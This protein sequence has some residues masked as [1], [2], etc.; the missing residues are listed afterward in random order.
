MRKRFV[1]ALVFCVI[2]SLCNS[3]KLIFENLNVNN[4]LPA[5]EVY[6]VIQDHKGYVWVFTEYGIVKHNGTNFV[7]VCKNISLKES[8]V[9]G[10]CEAPSGDIFFINS[11]SKVY[12]VRN[13]R[14]YRVKGIESATKFIVRTGGIFANNLHVDGKGTIRFST[15]DDWFEFNTSQYSIEGIPK[16]KKCIP[17]VETEYPVKNGKIT[18]PIVVNISKLFPDQ[19]YYVENRLVKEPDQRKQNTF[20]GRTILRKRHKSRYLANHQLLLVKYANGKVGRREIEN[21]IIAMEVDSRGFVW[22]GL[23]SGGLIELNKKLEIVNH[24]FGSVIVSDILFDD[25]DGMW[26]STIG[27]GVYHCANIHL[28]SYKELSELTEGISFI[29][30]ENNELFVGTKEGSLLVRRGKQFMSMKFSSEPYTVSDICFANNNY[31][32]ATHSGYWRVNANNLIIERLLKPGSDPPAPV[33][34][35]RSRG[36]NELLVVQ[37]MEV[38]T[39]DTEKRS[40]SLLKL[41]PARLRFLVE[42]NKGEFFSITAKG[43][44]RLVD[45]EIT[46]PKYLKP[47]LK[48]RLTKV[49]ID[50]LNN[51]WFCTKENTVFCLDKK[52]RLKRYSGL[53]HPII[54]DITFTSNNMVVLSTNT[55]VYACRNADFEKNKNWKLL[56][57]GEITQTTEFENILYVGTKNGLNEIDLASIRSGCK[58]RFYLHEVKAKARSIKFG[59]KITLKPDQNNVSFEYDLLKYNS[60]RQYLNYSLKGPLELSGRVTGSSIQFQNLASGEYQLTVYPEL[61]FE[62]RDKLIDKRIIV[63]LPAFWQTTWFIVLCVI[64]FLI[65]LVLLIW[66]IILRRNRKQEAQYRIERMLTEYR[67]TALKAQVNPHFMSNSLAAIQNLILQN[68]TDNATLYIAK[69]SLLLRSLL[70][71]SNKSSASLKNELEMIGL[72]VELEQLRFSHSFVFELDIDPEIDINETYIPALITQPFVENAIWH[73]LLPIDQA[74]TSRL[75]LKVSAENNS[76]VIS[77]IDNGVGRDYR[78]ESQKG[79]ESKGTDL[80]INRIETLNQLYQTTGGRVEIVDLFNGD[81]PTGTQVNIVLPQSMLNQFNDKY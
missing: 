13:D 5:S 35:I 23:R 15:L 42:R 70:E 66:I 20:N 50:R 73:G 75:T 30:I 22:L 27:K 77:V 31:F 9:Y 41:S 78:N 36:N 32:I 56:L 11:K 7:Q 4:G 34:G 60:N 29:Q 47:L 44:M 6:N 19:L 74:Q 52:N 12:C 57:G 16:K 48:Y 61:E 81:Q 80:I 40:R 53:P 58:Y 68:E 38:A 37:T 10:V 49:K 63:V 8:E 28:R 67:L 25:E 65:I 24:Y 26:V 18:D 71:Y 17:F 39:I 79:R 59:R 33:Y 2:A 72:Y 54:N 21:E 45:N 69:F 64:L 1:L 55:G 62:S 76:L 43:V 51:V 14:A 46:Y 3:Q